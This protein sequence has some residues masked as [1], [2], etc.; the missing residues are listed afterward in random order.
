MTGSYYFWK[1]ADNDLPGRPVDVH[2]ALLRGELH[3]ALQTFDARPLLKKLNSAATRGR[4]R[5]EEWDWEVTPHDEPGQA[6]FVFATCPLSKKTKAWAARCQREF[7]PL[8][9]SGSDEQNGQ[10]IP[11]LLP[12]LNV[13]IAGQLSDEPSYDIAVD[14]LPGLLRSIDPQKADPF[15]ALED[16]RSRFV[17][18]YAHGP[19]FCV[20]WRENYD[21]GIW[22]KF[23]QWRAQDRGRLATLDVPYDKDIA[24]SKDP[25]L[26][27][28]ADTLRIFEAF[29]LGEPRPEQYHWMNINSW[30]P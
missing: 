18:C 29:L 2:A 30:L 20:E 7:F 23:D 15:A 27:S 14:D 3:P 19:R 24:E 1:W 22:E 11:G 17:Q 28:Y 12:K 26:L 10:I 13:F 16:R 21:P 6:R 25:D 8:G 5:D 9:L 4:K